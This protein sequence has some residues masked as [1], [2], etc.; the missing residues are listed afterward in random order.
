MLIDG[1]TQAFLAERRGHI[2][3]WLLWVTAKNRS[4]GAAE[5]AGF[6]TGE[7]DETFVVDGQSRDYFGAGGF[8]DLDQITYESG[9]NVQRQTLRLAPITPEIE[10]TLRTYDPRLAPVELHMAIFDPDDNSLVSIT[11][12]IKGWIDAAPIRE[13]PKARGVVKTVCDL[14]I[15][16]A[17]RRGTRTV[18]LKKSDAAQKR[19]A[20]DRGRRYAAVSGLVPV[21]WGEERIE[22]GSGSGKGKFSGG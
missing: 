5:T 1:T 11:R 19:R 18:P 10:Q 15:V 6:W 16:T 7:D 17:A 8:F 4:T 13:D 3:R 9:L 14:S 21:W 2:V 20:G 12:A 22:P